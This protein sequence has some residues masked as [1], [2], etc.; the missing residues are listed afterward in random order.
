MNG[1]DQFISPNGANIYLNTAD[2]EIH[3]TGDKNL[4][5]RLKA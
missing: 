4:S 3:Q 2:S 5:P 1:V